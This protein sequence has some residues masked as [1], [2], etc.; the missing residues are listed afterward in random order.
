MPWA[1]PVGGAAGHF[2]GLLRRDVRDHPRRSAPWRW[3]GRPGNG[4]AAVLVAR[5]PLAALLAGVL[6]A[7]VAWPYRRS[8]QRKALAAPV[9]RGRA[10]GGAAELHAGAADNLL[11][12]RTGAAGAARARRASATGG[13]EHQMFPGVVISGRRCLVCGTA[14]GATRGRRTSRR[15]RSRRGRRAVARPEGVRPLYAGPADH[16]FGFQAIRAPAR[17]AVVAMLGLCVLAAL[18]VARRGFRTGAS[19]GCARDAAWIR[20]TRRCR[21]WRRRQ[22]D[23]GPLAGAEARA[24]RRWCICRSRSTARTRPSW[25]NRSSTAGRSSTATAASGRPSSRAGRCARG[26]GLGRRARRR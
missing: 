16:V 11:Y 24:R 21:W 23:R 14:G 9:R 17:F 15:W 12:G 26:P 3:P 8:Q 19:R 1:G 4:A 13:T 22:L 6:V 2:L 5:S 20:R 7:P 10:L 18:G 25:C